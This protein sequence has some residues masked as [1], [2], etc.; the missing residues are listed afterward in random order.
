MV[1]ATVERLSAADASN[2]VIDAP[3]QVDAFLLAG[4]LRPGGWVP[5]EGDPDLDQLRAVAP[6]GGTAGLAQVCASPMT[7][8]MD[9]DRPLWELLVV[10]GTASD[11][12]GLVLRIHHAVA[13]GVVGVAMLGALLD[14]RTG[15]DRNDGGAPSDPAARQ[16]PPVPPPRP[17]RRRGVASLLTGLTRVTAVLRATVPPTALLGPIGRHRGVAFAE[18]DLEPLTLAARSRGAT[19]N[20]AL[21]AAVAVAAKA[22]LTSA[23]HP[24]PPVLPA[25]VPVTLPDHRG[26]GNA[27]GVMLVELPTGEEDRGRRL[28]CIAARTSAAK[29]DARARGTLEVTRTRWSARLFARMARHQ[30]FVAL[31]VTNVRGP[32]DR[33]SLGGAPLGR[34]WPVTPLQGNVRLGVSALSYAGRLGCTVHVDGDVLDA[35]LLARVLQDELEVLSGG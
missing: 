24:V 5:T 14:E 2:V 31:F 18:V 35:D 12:P 28:G 32:R 11:G 26:S 3:D 20:D 21:L 23:G 10:P 30:H 25:S 19:V 15:S 13:D 6:V 4:V 27:V 33:L 34:A 8:P 7:R 29:A 1:P 9:P 17:S 16:S 22:A